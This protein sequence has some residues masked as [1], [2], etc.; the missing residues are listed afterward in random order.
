MRTN[1]NIGEKQ[2][3][4]I[5][6]TNRLICCMKMRNKT[7]NEQKINIMFHVFSIEESG[8]SKVTFLRF[9][10]YVISIFPLLYSFERYSSAFNKFEI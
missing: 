6:S 7:F 10:Y 1:K 4:G 8:A 5:L 3:A 9:S 2:M